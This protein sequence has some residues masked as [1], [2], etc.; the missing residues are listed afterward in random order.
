M[1]ILSHSVVYIQFCF[2]YCF[3][4]LKHVKHHFVLDELD[5]FY[6]TKCLFFYI[7]FYYNYFLATLAIIYISNSFTFRAKLE[8]SFQVTLSIEKLKC[9][10]GITVLLFSDPLNNPKGIN[11][12]FLSILILWCL[13]FRFRA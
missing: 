5:T 11:R 12:Y 2:C 3:E 1:H 6:Y 7:I 10:T 13:F 9:K 8:Q 4:I